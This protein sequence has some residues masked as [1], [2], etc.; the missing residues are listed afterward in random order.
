MAPRPLP[1]VNVPVRP[2]IKLPNA[3]DQAA[4][5]V[6][7]GN[8]DGK[9]SRDEW[10]RQGWSA[11]RFEAFDGNG[12]DAISEREF[13]QARGYEREFNQKDFNGDG[14]LS[15]SELSGIMRL[16]NAA[17]DGIKNL[18]DK[19]GNIIR[20]PAADRFGNMDKNN[21]GSIS[22][23]EYIE[24]RRNEDRFDN[25]RPL[26]APMPRP[27]PLDYLRKTSD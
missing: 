3:A 17:Q 22:R 14:K 26:P 7:D 12:N 24:G 1:D 15:R 8:G 21:D 9:I 27:I 25:I 20:W 23:N 4:F 2:S 11:E 10:R 18:G 6:L 16:Y 19:L 5:V 13:L